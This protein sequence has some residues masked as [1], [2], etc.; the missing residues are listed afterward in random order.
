MRRTSK[1][2]LALYALSAIMHF[3]VAMRLLPDLPVA[4]GIKVS[5]GIVLVASTLLIPASMIQSRKQHSLINTLIIW[6]GLIFMGLLSSQFVFTLVRDLLLLTLHLAE[7]IAH[8]D[9]L[10]PNWLSVSASAVVLASLAITGVGFLSIVSGPAVVKVEIPIQDLPA[11]L[12]SFRL[13]QL[14][15]I[16]IGPTIKRRFLQKV[17][18]RVN[19]L[20]VDAVVITGDLVDGRVHHLGQETQALAQLKS[21]AGT[22]FVTGNHEYYWHAEEWVALLKTLNIRI[23]M[24]EHAVIS[25]QGKQVVIAGVADY[26]AHQFIAQHRSDPERALRHA[27]AT[28]GL[29]ILLAHQPRSIFQARE[30]GAHVQLSGHTHGGQF[31]P[32]NHFV[33]LQQPFTSGLHWFE[34][35]W[36]YV[37]R[38]TGYWGPPKRFG[39]PA[40]ITLIRF[41]R[42]EL[43][44]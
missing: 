35:M 17:V 19:E 10:S 39:A 32:W 22:F 8:L 18:A 36:I 27:P 15:D 14:S 41:V 11:E 30:S 12:E 38:G 21:A 43:Q 3:Y 31:W 28:A 6:C 16:H 29:K 13:A 4:T 40:E 2:I 9:F 1:L 33:P 24:N 42:A 23:L 25:H 26:S 37:S 20:A 44:Q 5:L 34:T 7:Q